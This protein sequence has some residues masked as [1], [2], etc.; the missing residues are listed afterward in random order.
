MAETVISI[1]GISQGLCPFQPRVKVFELPPI[2]YAPPC[3]AG[4][5]K[6]NGFTKSKEQVDIF[7]GAEYQ[8]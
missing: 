2:P 6:A 3:A 7:R 8:H 4:A 5:R 1:P